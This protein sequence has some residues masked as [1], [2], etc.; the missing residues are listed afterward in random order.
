MTAV[1]NPFSLFM[2]LDGL[3]LT[4]GQI[5]VGVANANPE[6]SPIPAYWD[7]ARSIPA[8]QPLPTISGYLARSGTPTQAY[9]APSTYSLKVKDVSGNVIFYNQNVT[10]LTD[11][12]QTGSGSAVVGTSA[13]GSST[14]R[15]VQNVLYYPGVALEDFGGVQSNNNA[16]AATNSLALQS[17]LGAG[18]RTILIGNGT[19]M[20]NANVITQAGVKIVG[21]GRSS[22]LKANT[23]V[24][25]D[26]FIWFQG[27]NCTIENCGVE[28]NAYTTFAAGQSIH[29]RLVLFLKNP[30]TNPVTPIKGVVVK[31]CTIYGGNTSIWVGAGNDV[32]IDNNRCDKAWNYGIAIPSGPYSFKITRNTCTNTAVQ[33]GIKFGFNAGQ[34]AQTGGFGIVAQNLIANCGAVDPTRANWQEGLDVYVQNLSHV[35]IVDNVIM[36]CGNGGIEIKSGGGLPVPTLSINDGGGIQKLIVSRNLIRMKYAQGTGISMHW[37]SNGTATPISPTYPGPDYL[38]NTVCS[39]NTIA[40]EGSSSE[41]LLTRQDVGIEVDGWTDVLVGENFIVNTGQCIRTAGDGSTDATA[42]RLTLRGNIGRGHTGYGINHQNGGNEELHILNN[43]VESALDPCIVVL[44]TNGKPALRTLVRGNRFVSKATETAG[45]VYACR[46][47]ACLGAVVE[48][49]LLEAQSRAISLGQ[50]M[51]LDTSAYTVAK[52]GSVRRNTLVLR[53]T[54][55]DG[56]GFLVQAANFYGVSGAATT[57][58]YLD[59]KIMARNVAYG[60]GGFQGNDG[61]CV[62]NARDNDRGATL[63]VAP[64]SASPAYTGSSG[65]VLYNAQ[66][67]A[68]GPLRMDQAIR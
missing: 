47:D 48:D 9:V 54:D 13:P 24:S 37:A 36:D 4:G 28:G 20:M 61:F 2:G 50:S 30:A 23:A 67:G 41:A 39:N 8:L 60:H 66:V 32:E 19:Y 55:A 68:S 27:D 49:N 29:N 33:E 59:N 6:T 17:A 21:L 18:Y 14:V 65:D 43:D 22:K 52:G 53:A 7:A 63:N 44:G 5:Y 57:Y 58:Q 46:I 11:Q 10:S 35:E 45:S 34:T 16:D 25:T 15:T 26:G 3:P 62:L 31:G 56:T 40:W 12:I 38:G 1:A 51:P 42:R 64:A